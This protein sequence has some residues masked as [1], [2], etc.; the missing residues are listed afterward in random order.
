[1]DTEKLINHVK[2]CKRNLKS[3]RV[4]CCKSCPFEDEIIQE[5]SE[6]KELFELK[7]EKCQKKK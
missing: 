3:D 1:M 6:L 4:E 2:L 7:R 5:Y